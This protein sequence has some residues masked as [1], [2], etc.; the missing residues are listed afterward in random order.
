VREQAKAMLAAWVEMPWFRKNDYLNM[1]VAILVSLALT[2]YYLFQL[3]AGTYGPLAMTT[4]YYDLLCEGFRRGHLYV[5]VIPRPELLAKPNPF[6]TVN[7]PLWLWDAS[8]YKKHYYMYWGPVPALCL[9]VFKVLIGSTKEVVDQWIGYYFALGRLYA[10]AGLVVSFA[11]YS[12]TRQRPWVVALAILAFGLASPTPFTVARMHVYETSL[13]AGQCFL[14]GGLLA[15]Y[16][17]IMRESKRTLWLVLASTCW[18]LA[19]CSHVSSC[20]PVPLFILFTA[21]T[22]WHR[23]ERSLKLGF[24]SLLAL[25]IPAT[26]FVVAHAWYNYARFDSIFEFGINHQ[27]TG[28]KFVRESKY[29][30]PNI[31]SYLFAGVDWSCRFPFV[32]APTYRPLSKLIHWPSGYATFERAAGMFPTA[33]VTWLLAIWVWRPL[34]FLWVRANARHSYSAPRISAIETWMLLCAV[35]NALAMY[36]TLGQWEASMRYLGDAISG[37]LMA[38]FL[39]AFWLL[40]RVDYCG[41]IKQR[42]WYHLGFAALAVHTGFVG[43]F[44]GIATYGDLWQHSNPKLYHELE[45]SWSS[46]PAPDGR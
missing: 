45:K 5:P 44:S 41:T 9:L 42:F 8:L 36:P 43:A 15:A 25:G 1:V 30:F 31:F 16:W 28:Q 18:G 29:I 22:M 2:A 26:C 19:L 32:I 46:C 39:A 40:R 21:F 13:M 11:N 3:T 34:K 14:V 12:R 20:V 27:V 17:G 4:N 33:A 24:K 35:A 23:G 37:L 6:D 38:S 10:G 7:M